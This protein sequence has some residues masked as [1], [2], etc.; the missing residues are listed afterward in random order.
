MISYD[1][2][3]K[4][5]EKKNISQY[6]LLQEGIDNKTIY[7]LKRNLNITMVN[8]EKLCKIVHGTPNDVVE[9]K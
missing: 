7:R 1:P 9:F 2:L 3:W 4:T 8:L 6:R 5:M